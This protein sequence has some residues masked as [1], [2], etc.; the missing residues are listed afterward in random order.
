MNKRTQYKSKFRVGQVVRLLEPAI[1]NVPRNYTDKFVRIIR[2]RWCGD[3]NEWR[4]A[5]PNYMIGWL[6]ESILRPLTKSERG[7]PCDL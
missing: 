1:K 7:Q 4:Y 3:R 6:S 5:A 2:L